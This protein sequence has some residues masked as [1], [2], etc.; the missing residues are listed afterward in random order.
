[1]TLYS[2]IRASGKDY[3]GF[4]RRES[5]RSERDKVVKVLANE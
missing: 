5:E 2:F 3:G 4:S 1:M